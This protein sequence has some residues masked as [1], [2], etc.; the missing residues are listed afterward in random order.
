MF[1]L[2]PINIWQEK[3]NKPSL[4]VEDII[5]IYP[6]VD[7]SI[8]YEIL[9]RR[10]VFKWFSV[11]RELIKFKDNLKQKTRELNRKKT[12]EEKGY[13][14][15]IELCR[16]VI[17]KLCHSTRWKAPDFDSKANEFLKNYKN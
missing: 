2:S 14:K 12:K 8:V 15:A 17:R 13:L 3:Q 1:N 7:P 16:K 4:I 6:N 11:R 5:K 9:L 10:G